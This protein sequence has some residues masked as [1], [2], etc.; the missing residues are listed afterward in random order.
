MVAFAEAG[1]IDSDGGSGK[2]AAARPSVKSGIA[3]PARA[4]VGFMIT[5]VYILCLYLTQKS[6]LWFDLY[7]VNA[8]AR[9]VYSIPLRVR[10]QN[11]CPVC[12]HRLPSNPGNWLLAPAGG[13][14]L[15]A[16]WQIS[17]FRSTSP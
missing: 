1:A 2:V 5:S 13:A 7:R 16:I 10:L 12:A 3:R 8:F 9:S 11:R 15:Y 4:M 6:S 14:A 17:R